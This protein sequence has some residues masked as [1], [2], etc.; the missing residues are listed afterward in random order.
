MEVT[1]PSKVVIEEISSS[2]KDVGRISLK[3]IRYK[4]LLAIEGPEVDDCCTSQVVQ[5]CVIEKE[6]ATEEGDSN[7]EESEYGSD[8]DNPMFSK[9]DERDSEQRNARQSKQSRER[10]EKQREEEF[11]TVNVEQNVVDDPDYNS[12]ALEN[13]HSS[14]DERGKKT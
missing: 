6:E 13:V 12:D 8:V 7:S 11:D 1:G 9:F 4:G 5:T 14:D 2:E 3:P 10:K